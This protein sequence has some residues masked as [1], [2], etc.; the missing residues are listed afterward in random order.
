MNNDRW[1]EKCKLCRRSFEV[2]LFTRQRNYCE[3]CEIE[4]DS[5]PGT[6]PEMGIFTAGKKLPKPS[7]CPDVNSA[8][9]Q[10]SETEREERWTRED[11]DW[12]MNHHYWGKHP[13][14]R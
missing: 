13:R 5:D 2:G 14:D 12:T 9:S 10:E 6:I 1:I 11:H 3:V 4:L 7:D 8:P